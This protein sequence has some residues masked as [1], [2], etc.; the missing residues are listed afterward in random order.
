M[1]F[2]KKFQSVLTSDIDIAVIQECENKEKLAQAFE[3]VAYND[4]IWIGNNPNKGVAIISFNNYRVT[5]NSEYNPEFEYIIPTTIVHNKIEVNLFAIWAMPHKQSPKKGYVGQIWNAINYYEELLQSTSILVGDFNSNQMW[6]KKRKIGNHSQVVEYLKRN[7]IV[8]LY[9]KFRNIP[10]GKE[11]DPT[12]F[13]LKNKDKKYHMDYCFASTS[14]L[15]EKTT[16][17]VGQH[18]DWIDKS[19]HMPIWIENIDIENAI[20]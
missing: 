1:A 17:D 4:L 5:L 9:H 20:A 2:R 3:D 14:L 19:D 12:L 13:L 18:K 6:D 11:K 10:H 16:F 8:S 7:N 15:T